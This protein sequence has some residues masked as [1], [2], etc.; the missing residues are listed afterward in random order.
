MSDSLALRC[1]LGLDIQMSSAMT[2]LGEGT[3]II[4]SC[5]GRTADAVA[6]AATQHEA[7]GRRA[8]RD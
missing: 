7:I 4:T 8:R 1:E 2:L 3:S 6:M 5:A